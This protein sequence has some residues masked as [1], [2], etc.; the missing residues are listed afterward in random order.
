MCDEYGK[1]LIR[2]FC[3][4]YQ[5]YGSKRIVEEIRQWPAGTWDYRVKHDPIPNVLPQGVDVHIVATVEPDEGI[6]TIDMRD[7][8]DCQDCGLNMSEATVTGSARAGVLNRMAADLPHNE[9][10]MRHIRVLQRDNCIVGRPELPHSASMAT[11]NLADRVISGVQCLL[12]R[13]T[14]VR[15]MAEGGAVQSPALSVISGLDARRGSEPYINQL[16]CGQTGGPGVL[17]H[18]GWV[19]YQLPNTGGALYWAS[20]EVVE[21]RYPMRVVM[22]ELISDSAGAGQWDAV[23]ACKFAFTP[24]QLP[25]MAAYSCD[26]IENVPK[27]A[28]GGLDGRPAAAWK[29]RLAEGEGSRVDLLAFD[30]P[31]IEFGEALVSECSSGGGYGDP[32]DRDPDLVRHRVREGWT[33]VDRARDVYG[34]VLDLTPE[35][36]A[37]D[38]RATEEL[39]TEKRAARTQAAGDAGVRVDE[40]AEIDG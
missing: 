35:L 29:Y 21:Q 8:A 4:A 36:Y 13:V 40:G 28:K 18:D 3:D 31:V 12:N 9:G 30:N 37:V 25:V 15:G 23:P 22:T 1:D 38:H 2:A 39:R 17:G 26:G 7:N 11:S 16:F 33:S 27:G 34:V 20:V 19:T 32:L 24:Q 14:D 10:A 6:I 5:E